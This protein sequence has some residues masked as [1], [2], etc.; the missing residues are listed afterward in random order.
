MAKTGK[1]SSPKRG[2]RSRPK[3]ARQAARGALRVS[4]DVV[5]RRLGDEV[6]LVNLQTDRVYALNQTAARIWEL[7]ASRRSPQFIERTLA[8]EFA[9][10]GPKLSREIGRLLSTLR[11]KKLVYRG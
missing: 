4:G 7:L 3:R 2:S 10:E 11:A 1:K 6:I 5:S 8:R 9:A